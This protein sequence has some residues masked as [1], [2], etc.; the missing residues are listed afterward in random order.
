M[1]SFA[2]LIVLLGDRNAPAPIDV[3]TAIN[4]LTL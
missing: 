1:V 4:G 2:L 3:D